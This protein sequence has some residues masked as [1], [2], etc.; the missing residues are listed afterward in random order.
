MTALS[1]LPSLD[2][3]GEELLARLRVALSAPGAASASSPSRRVPEDPGVVV[4]SFARALAA[5]GR[6]AHTIRQYSF[7]ARALLRWV[8]KPL[9][10]VRPSDL[11]SYLEHLAIDRHYS[12]S[13]LYATVRGLA[14]LFR[15]F[16]LRTADAL[17]P[18]KRP[19][20]VPSYL[21]EQEVRDLLT[22]A[23]TSPRDHAIA[24]ILATAG[25]RVGELCRLTLE[26]LDT[27][28]GIL[29]IRAGKGDKDRDVV[30]DGR[31]PVAIERYLR[32]TGR[33]GQRVG[34]LFDI[35]PVSVERVV[36]R[37]ALAA[38]IEK[39]VTPHTLRHS[40]ATNLLNRGVDIRF[41]K[42]LLGHS[43]TATTEV[44][45]SVDRRSLR[46]AVD[47]AGALY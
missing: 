36:S 38:G 7:F 3:D 12:K 43:S 6:S 21:G 44:Y 22:A 20:R 17:E 26:D 40:F 28:S 24:M 18:P 37:A 25:V 15:S 10:E 30:L 31:I 4:S 29:H 39:R 46:E 45:C 5:R 11:Q 32:A 23:S 27:E 42:E 19:V 41:L 9:G 33:L 35:G 47:R 34:R 14:C 1:S 2:P 13:S 8:A 16:G